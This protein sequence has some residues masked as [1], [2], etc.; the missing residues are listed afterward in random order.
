MA[1]RQSS[2]T[3]AMGRALV[4]GM[5]KLLAF[6]S[7]VGTAAMLWV[8]GQIIVHGLHIHPAEWFGLKEGLL[9]WLVDAGLCGLFGLLLGSLIV[10]VHHWWVK[11]SKA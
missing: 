8:G 11:R 1:R 4:N 10:A 6:L 5:P 9:A 2:G 7:V 3:Q